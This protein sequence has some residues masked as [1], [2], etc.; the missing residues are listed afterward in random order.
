MKCI[1]V[2]RVSWYVDMYGK[3]YL[4][5]AFRPLSRNVDQ[6]CFPI[7]CVCV[8]VCVFVFVFVFVCVGLMPLHILALFHPEAHQSL[9]VLAS[10]YKEGLQSR[11]RV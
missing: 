6:I 5:F 1:Y 3:I 4:A 10:I 9:A 11:D 7:R 2:D 8:C